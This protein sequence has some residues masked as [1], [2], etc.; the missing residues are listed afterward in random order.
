MVKKRKERNESIIIYT[1]LSSFFFCWLGSCNGLFDGFPDGPRV[2]AN[3]HLTTP[4]FAAF[5]FLAVLGGDVRINGFPFALS[6]SSSYSKAPPFKNKNTHR[7][8]R[9]FKSFNVPV[10]RIDY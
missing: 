8:M 3:E 4:G 2:V 5:F 1:F 9:D 7:E 6:F 10:G